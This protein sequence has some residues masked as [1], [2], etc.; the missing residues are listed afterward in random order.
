MEAVMTFVFEV[1]RVYIKLISVVDV[2]GAL[3]V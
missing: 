3:R 1:S 2:S